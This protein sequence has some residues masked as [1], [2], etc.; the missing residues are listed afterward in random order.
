MHKK[1]AIMLFVGGDMNTTDVLCVWT[2]HFS[3][4]LYVNHQIKE[5]DAMI[6]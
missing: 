4:I 5:R 1:L 2:G 3:L 6:Y